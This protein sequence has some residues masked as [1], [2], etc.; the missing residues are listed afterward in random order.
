MTAFMAT[1]ALALTPL[2]PIHVGCGEDF[3]PTNYVID[4][5][6]LHHFDPARVPMTTDERRRLRQTVARHGDDAIR[7]V[8]QF[9]YNIRTKCIQASWLRVPVAAGVAEWYAERVGQISQREGP[10]RTV[11]NQLEIERTAHHPHTGRPYL[12]G[13]SVKGS[14]RTAWL[15]QID[16]SSIMQ[17]NADEKP[18]VRSADVET[19]LLGGSFSS[20]PFRLVKV[21]DAEGASVAS[22][23]VFSVDRDKQPRIG[24]DGRQT[25]KNLF[26]RREVIAAAQYRALLGE[27]RLEGLPAVKDEKDVP[28][29]DKRIRSL[30]DLACACNRFYG[31]RLRTDLELIRRRFA[32]DSWVDSLSDLL[33]AMKE[34]LDSGRAM[35]LRVGRHSGAESVTLEK[36]RWIRIMK[37]RGSAQWGREATTIWLAAERADSRSE[38]LPFGFVLA[39]LGSVTPNT[40]L[41]RWCEEEAKQDAHRMAMHDRSGARVSAPSTA[42][43]SVPQEVVWDRARLKFNARNGTL[44]AVGRDNVEANAIS[45]R[46]VELLATL[47]AGVQQKVRANQFVQVAATVRGRELIAIEVKS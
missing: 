7:G 35:L 23:I 6:V 27:I 4:G 30:A 26:V 10:G 32:D 36:R 1:H 43:R 5:A 37:G 45:P 22:R 24:R 3:E 20:D 42:T 34:D 14:I 13:S 28:R 44:T 11:S 33:V 21:S 47:P 46:G 16:P 18:S 40:A 38:L 17:G 31:E 15:N 29:T 25:E 41:L 12:P 9:F 8:Q 39:E 2:T 19:E